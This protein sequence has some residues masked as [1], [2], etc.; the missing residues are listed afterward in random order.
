MVVDKVHHP[1]VHGHKSQLGSRRGPAV[2]RHLHLY[3]RLF[4]GTVG[5]FGIFNLDLIMTALVININW[6]N[7]EYPLGLV[8][9]RLVVGV[10]RRA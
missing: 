6:R 1:P 4:G 8:K 5:R 2:K 3:L 9:V 7:A 10:L